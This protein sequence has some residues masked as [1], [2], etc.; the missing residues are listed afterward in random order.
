MKKETAKES[1]RSGS[2][3]SESKE[4]VA[5]NTEND[6]RRTKMGSRQNLNYSG[7]VEKSKGPFCS[8]EY[9]VILMR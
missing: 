4:A 9:T 7:P 2:E 3:N 8:N 5:A 1:L 6:K